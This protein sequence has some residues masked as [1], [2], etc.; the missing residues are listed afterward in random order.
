MEEY[1]ATISYVREKMTTPLHLEEV[2]ILHSDEE[3]AIPLH[4]GDGT[5]LHLEE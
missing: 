3:V 2:A 5:P 4:F 1:V